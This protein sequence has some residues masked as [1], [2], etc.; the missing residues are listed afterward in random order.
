MPAVKNLIHETSTTTSTGSFT[1]SAVNGKVRFSDGTYGFGTGS[2]QNV[3][4][5]FASNRDAAEWEYGT[6][7]MSDANTLV[8]DTVIAGSNGASPVNFSAGTKDITNDIP[9]E[10]QFLV[11]AAMS[12]TA[13]QKA[14]AR[15]N[16]AVPGRTR[17]L[18]GDF[19]VSQRNGTTA[20]STADN[21]HWAD[22]WR[23]IG[24]ASATCTGRS[25]SLGGAYPFEGKILFTG[26]TDKGGAWH[27]LSGVN[28]KDLRGSVVCLSAVLAVN[29]T[30]LGNLKMGIA[31]FTG[32]EDSVSGDPVATW[33]AD[34]TTPTLATNWAFINTPTNLSVTTSPVLYSVT[35]TVGASANNLAVMIWNDDKSYSAND[36]FYLTDV[37]LER[38]SVPTE[39][40]RVSYASMLQQCLFYYEK[41]TNAAAQFYGP[42]ACSTTTDAFGIINHA[43]KRIA[44]TGTISTTNLGITNGAGATAATAASITGHVTSSRWDVSVASGLTV[45][46]FAMLRA[47]GAH[48]IELNSE[49]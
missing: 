17:L 49:L 18:N 6:G 29:N 45:G 42:G 15:A 37:Q 19:K 30:R 4:D 46:A 12:L 41:I 13:T 43:P 25:Q 28:S 20:T 34:G 32:T 24:E 21:A 35:G 7:H 27:V 39:F 14:Q 5:Y 48:S 3:L 33:G 36:F 44:P 26:T 16:I 8:R 31:E 10:R 22:R 38:G 47:S 40:D 23:Y 1:V 2:T 11:D 9:A